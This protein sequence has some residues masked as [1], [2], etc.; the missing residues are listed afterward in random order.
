[1]RASDAFLAVI[2]LPKAG[3]DAHLFT[4]MAHG[5]HTT[6]QTAVF[7]RTREDIAMKSPDHTF[8]LAL[9]GESDYAVICGPYPHPSNRINGYA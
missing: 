2:L 8:N 1:M 7:T 3:A 4:A 5:H 6:A 9:F